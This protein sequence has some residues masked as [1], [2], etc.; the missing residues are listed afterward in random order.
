M[1]ILVSEI[2]IN[3]N[4][5][6]EL[7]HK[8]MQKSIECGATYVKI[9]MRS[10]ELCVPKDQWYK[11]KLTP[12]GETMEYINY[13]HRM[14]FTDIQLEGFSKYPW[15]PSVFDIEA[16]E[17]AVRFR[18]PFIKLPSCAI[19]DDSLLQAAIDTDIP[20]ITSTGMSTEQEVI[21]MIGMLESARQETWILHCNSS[22]PTKDEEVNLSAMN[23]LKK[24]APFAHIGFSSHSVSPLVPVASIYLGAEMIEAHFTTDRSLPGGDMSASL[25]PTG[26]AL[27]AREID[28]SKK[29]IGDGQLRLYESEIEPRK[30]LRGY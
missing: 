11:P 26:L 8:M 21:H 13:R 9:Q 5:D 23:T 18:P 28:R 4:S 22:Y 2:G 3:W 7:A 16:L 17:R 20:L 6:Y 30:K 24:L 25:E 15:F 1:T 10:P 19:T 27:I 29:I 14:E 12:W